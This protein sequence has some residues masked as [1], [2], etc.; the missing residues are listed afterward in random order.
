VLRGRS[1]QVAVLVIGFALACGPPPAGAAFPG[2]NG[3]IAFAGCYCTTFPIHTINPDGSGQTDLTLGTDPGWSADGRKLAYI[4]NAN[5]VAVM[6]ADGSGQTDL[7]V[8]PATGGIDVNDLHDPAWSPDD[9]Q[10]AFDELD[11]YPDGGCSSLLWI[12]NADGSGRHGLLAPAE[13]YGSTPTWSPDGRWI[14][15]SGYCGDPTTSLAIC[16]AH[17]DGTGLTPLF[18]RPDGDSTSP[19][20]SPDGS[21]IVFALGDSI[22]KIRSD[23]TGSQVL[24]A[25]AVDS[26]GSQP[27][28]SA[29]GSKIAFT[30]ETPQTR[31]SDVYVMNS[32]G[33]NE[34]RLSAGN[35][36]S[37]QQIPQS[38]VRPKGATPTYASLVPSYVACTSPNTTHGGPL[39]YPSCTQQTFNRPDGT[40]RTASPNLTIGSP[41]AN[42][43]AAKFTGFVRLDVHPGN[44]ATPADEADVGIQV[45]ATDI[46]CTP[47]VLP[48]ECGDPNSVVGAGADYLGELRGNLGLRITD[49]EN[50]PDPGAAGPGT[51]LDT[52]FTFTVP[53]AGTTDQTVGSSCSTNTTAD[54]VLPGVVEEGKRSVWQ[55]GQIQVFDGGPDGDV[56]TPAGDSLFLTQG[57]FAF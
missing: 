26:S 6:N 3:Q 28:W 7:G 22:W 10:I 44:P 56:G 24:R 27:A 34:T 47:S 45:G 21:E 42:G 39:F 2:A 43:A 33:S 17:P 15:F 30:L 48:A 31:P 37:W 41:D 50:T 23:G 49:R 53:C 52:S 16:K 35:S 5:H 57:L 8:G 20:W 19:D 54:A 36:P 12:V 38:Y 55:M 11:C 29:D 4:N 18:V 32:D 46:R 14:A 51:M 9:R 1:A 25:G 40:M 13:D